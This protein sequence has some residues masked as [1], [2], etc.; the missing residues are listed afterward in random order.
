GV[1]LYFSAELVVGKQKLASSEGNQRLVSLADA[2]ATGCD[3]GVPKVKRDLCR[4]S[5]PVSWAVYNGSWIRPAIARE[6]RFA[7]SERRLLE[8]VHCCGDSN[9]RSPDG[10][11]GL[12]V[13]SSRQEAQRSFAIAPHCSRCGT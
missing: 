5:Q 4:A 1:N 11:A 6:T 10:S 13:R 2:A 8:P 12:A 7:I 9:S 3:L